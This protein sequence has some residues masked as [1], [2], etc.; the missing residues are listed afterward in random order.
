MPDQRPLRAPDAFILLVSALGIVS[1]LVLITVHF[2]VK[3]VCPMLLGIPSCEFGLV[4]YAAVFASPFVRWNAARAILFW[5]GTT[6]GLLLAVRFSVPQAAGND[7]CP[8]IG[9]VP[10]CYVSLVA[11]AAMI[12]VKVAFGRWGST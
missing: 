3:P 7:V 4:A 11:F 10:L 1:A 5:S 6:L 2:G 8:A 9:S 12:F